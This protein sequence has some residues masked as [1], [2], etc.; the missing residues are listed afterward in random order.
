M[1]STV[2]GGILCFKHLLDSPD[3]GRHYFFLINGLERSFLKVISPWRSLGLFDVFCN[4][5]KHGG[6]LIETRSL[7]HLESPE[8]S[9]DGAKRTKDRQ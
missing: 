5:C 8:A 4:A 1:H 2:G 9:V 7:L 6:H 3:F